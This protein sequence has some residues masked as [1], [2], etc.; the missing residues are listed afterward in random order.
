MTVKYPDALLEIR[1]QEIGPSLKSSTLCAGYELEKW[2]GQQL[3]ENVFEW[4]PYVALDQESQLS[5]GISNFLELLNL[6]CKHIYKTKKKANRGEIGEILLHI[7]CVQQFKAFPVLCKLVLKTSP[8]DTVKGFDGIYVVP[9]K[10]DFEIWLGES[11]F[12]VGGKKAIKDAVDSIKTHILPDFIKAEKAMVTAHIDK[13]APY[14]EELKSILKL[15]SSADVLLKK[16]VF[17]ILIAYDSAT[18][19][20]HIEV[21]NEYVVS[22]KEEI[23]QLH[24][25]FATS[26][27]GLNLRFNLIFVPLNTKKIVVEHFDKLLEP[28]V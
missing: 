7:A 11:K 1:I 9:K 25:T 21:C 28:H 14:Y 6:A 10:N 24:S 18:C 4:I 13:N 2:R 16:A 3:A 8:N 26:S 17:P 19:A 15:K 12:Y 5:F 27:T 20:N 23:A 22:L